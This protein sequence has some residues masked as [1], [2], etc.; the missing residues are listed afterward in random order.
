[1]A[2]TAGTLLILTIIFASTSIMQSK[3]ADSI[4]I[5][6]DRPLALFFHADFDEAVERLHAQENAGLLNSGDGLEDISTRISVQL[7][8]DETGLK[9][10]ISI[11]P[12][13]KAFPEMKTRWW[14]RKKKCED[15]SAR[16]LNPPL[17]T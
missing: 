11:R 1:M 16:R 12:L 15:G 5:S 13:R 10:M 8:R 17:S 7:T 9:N 3:R 6:K 4:G 14:R 2:C